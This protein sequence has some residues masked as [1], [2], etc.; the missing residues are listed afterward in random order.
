MIFLSFNARGVRGVPKFIALKRLVL[1]SRPDF[2][3]VQDTMCSVQ[4]KLMFFLVF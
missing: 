1:E 2:V 3:M 4:N